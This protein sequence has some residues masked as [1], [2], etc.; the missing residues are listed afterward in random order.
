M[1]KLKNNQ[2]TFHLQSQFTTYQLLAQVI[3]SLSGDVEWSL[4]IVVG[5]ICAG[6]GPQQQSHG[7]GLVL[8]DT[9]VKWSVS[10]LGLAIKAAGVL[11]QKINNMQ[12]TACFLGNGVMK[13]SLLKFL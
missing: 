5:K 1:E 7:L 2:L 10:F 11:N 4:A 12:R 9:I 6:S 13:T 3:S 8:D